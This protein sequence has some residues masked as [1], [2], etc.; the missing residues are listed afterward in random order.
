M[1]I[2]CI[3]HN[4]YKHNCNKIILYYR[5]VDVKKIEK[6]NLISNKLFLKNL[7]KMYNLY[8]VNNIHLKLFKYKGLNNSIQLSHIYIFTLNNVQINYSHIYISG[9]QVINIQG[10][11][12]YNTFIH[13]YILSMHEKLSLMKSMLLLK[14]KHA[15]LFKKLKAL[16]QSDYKF[17][18]P[19]LLILWD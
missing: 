14:R 19:M 17:P 2:I 11:Y 18:C 5:F 9:I 13:T 4:A 12:S 1:Y 10:P 8:M 3:S 7:Q 6:Q 15:L 16:Y